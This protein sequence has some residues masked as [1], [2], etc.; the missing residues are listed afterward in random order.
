MS[1]LTATLSVSNNRCVL[2]KPPE[3][4]TRISHPYGEL[5]AKTLVNRLTKAG[6]TDVK[7]ETSGTATT[8]HLAKEGVLIRLEDHSTHILDSVDRALRSKVQKAVLDSL[9]KF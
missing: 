5:N 6:F 3:I 4:S 8:I 9:D 1:S 7:T 2:Q